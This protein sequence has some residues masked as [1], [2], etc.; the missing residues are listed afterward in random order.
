MCEELFDWD[1][2][3]R[4]QTLITGFLAVA[5]AL[6]TALAIYFSAHAPL[7]AERKTRAEEAEARRRAHALAL[8]VEVKH[9]EEMASVIN[10][11]VAESDYTN[12]IPPDED[13]WRRWFR[14]ETPPSLRD[15]RLV[16]VHPS[17]IPDRLYDL[18][19]ALLR[20]QHYV[21]TIKDWRAEA[22]YN[23]TENIIKSA[24]AVIAALAVEY[25]LTAR[26]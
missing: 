17:P 10:Y 3:E 15:W 9:V 21:D 16:A 8:L 24:T 18:A 5:A 13:G 25:D 22:I 6:G 11:T 12:K 14:L 2:I 26:P 1:Y 7:K 23:H 4:F 19:L 20:F